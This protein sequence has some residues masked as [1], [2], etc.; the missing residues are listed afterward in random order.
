[1][2]NNIKLTY[3]LISVMLLIGIIPMWTVA[4]VSL[5]SASDS[6]ESEA[7]AKLE[8]TREFK[9]NAVKRHFDTSLKIINAI[10]KQPDVIKA[11]GGFPWCV[12][13]LSDG[14]ESHRKR[15]ACLSPGTW[16]VL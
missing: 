3:R 16:S 15:V 8:S 6:I 1:M 7:F 2:L 4:W 14:C 5:Q 9:G 12:C 10:A 13:V 11:A